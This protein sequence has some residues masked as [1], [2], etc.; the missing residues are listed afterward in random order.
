MERLQNYE[1]KVA[2]TS[3]EWPNLHTIAIFPA[4]ALKGVKFAGVCGGGRERAK[5]IRR[6]NV[7]R[8]LVFRSASARQLQRTQK[9][10]SRG[11]QQ[12][13]DSIAEAMLEHCFARRALDG[14]RAGYIGEFGI[15]R[16][17]EGVGKLR[18]VAV[19]TLRSVAPVQEV[20]EDRE[21]HQDHPEN[22][23]VPQDE[24]D[25]D[26]IK[27]AIF[28]NY[29]KRE[30]ALTFQRRQARVPPARREYSRCRG[31]S[32]AE[33]CDRHHRVSGAGGSRR[34]RSDWRRG[35]RTRPRHARQFPSGR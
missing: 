31:A 27:H 19:G 4:M 24:P 2:S 35:Q 26:G 21:K 3:G 28:S 22:D 9:D 16:G 1:F 32:E 15:K 23:A 8:K 20:G 7:G 14:V 33:A 6:K 25:A 30:S 13:E 29:R 5:G 12:D 34:L 10:V 17:N 18:D 11:I